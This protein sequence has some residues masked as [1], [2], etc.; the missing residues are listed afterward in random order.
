MEY[1]FRFTF[2]RNKQFVEV[3]L[4][5][6]HPTTFSRWGGGA[7]GYF[8]ACYTNPRQGRFGELHFVKDRL[9]YDVVNHELLHVLT[10]WMWA[11][12]ETITRKNEERYATFFDEITR[13]FI[14]EL[15]RTNPR[16]IL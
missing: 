3:S 7:W 2:N 16:I 8:Q 4:W 10:E 5:E 1:D 12:G 14:R 13:K 11:G 9:R 6:V 15:R